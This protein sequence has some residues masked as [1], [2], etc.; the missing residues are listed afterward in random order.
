MSIRL[1]NGRSQTSPTRTSGSTSGN[2]RLAAVLALVALPSTVVHAVTAT[3]LNS[4]EGIEEPLVRYTSA[5]GAFAHD[6]LVNI[7]DQGGGMFRMRLRYRSDEWDGDRDTHNTDRQR[8]EV[9]GLGPHQKTGETFEYATSWRTSPGLRAA[10]RFC[11]VFQLKS[12]NGDSGAPLV[13]ISIDEG[14]ANTSVR[15]WSGKAKTATTVREFPWTPGEWTTVRLRIKTSRSVEGADDGEVLASVNGDAFQGARG[16]AVFRT[17]A[18]DYRPKWGFYRGA[19]PGLTLD[20]DYVEHKDVSAEKVGA[21]A[22]LSKQVVANV[23]VAV[24]RAGTDPAAALAMAEKL[25]L[26]DGRWEAMAAAFSRWTDRDADAALRWA[27]KHGP[28]AELDS[29]LWYFA[30]DTTLRYV[31]RE[32][33]LAGAALIGEPELRA[34]AVEHVVLIWARREPAA[35]M[36]WVEACAALTAEQKAAIVGKIHAARKS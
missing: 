24:E 25:S 30:T 13:T 32:K 11:H 26:A 18:N 8:A 1:G 7:T 29:L 14:R 5:T 3:S 15:V 17:G 22:A 21:A 4:F 20:D 23:A 31:V 6:D 2:W 12:T 36:Q 35:A 27:A 10:S 16:I 28:S 33:A 19:K 34:R 9:K